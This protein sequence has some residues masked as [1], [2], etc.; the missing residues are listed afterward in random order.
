MTDLIE[1]IRAILLADPTVS[2]QTAGR[3]FDNEFPVSYDTSMPQ[4]SVIIRASGGSNQYGQGTL[5]LRDRRFHTITYGETAH[6]A[7]V[8]DT[9]VSDCLKL[10]TPGIWAHTYIHWVKL[11]VGPVSMRDPDLLWPYLTSSY[12][13]LASEITVT[14]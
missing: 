6:L 11:A 12:N 4:R 8:V 5:Q 1:G 13:V 3:V 14:A 9:A 7:S 10:F 2:T